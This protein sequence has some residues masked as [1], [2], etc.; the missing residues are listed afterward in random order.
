VGGGGRWQHSADDT[1]PNT[2]TTVTD[3]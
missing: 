2:M 1:P 3:F